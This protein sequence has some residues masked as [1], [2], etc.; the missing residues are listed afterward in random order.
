MEEISTTNSEYP[1]AIASFMVPFTS[2]PLTWK[3]FSSLL[4]HCT[5]ALTSK[6]VGPKYEAPNIPCIYGSSSY[7]DVSCIFN[8]SRSLLSI[9]AVSS[10]CA[11]FMYCIYIQI[12]EGCNF[13]GLPKSRISAILFSWISSVLSY[14]VLQVYY[15]CFNKIS[16]I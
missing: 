8:Y 4:H 10:L 6:N 2:I 11:V 16:R 13:C 1:A 12:F 5:P 14:L 7:D 9:Y 15:N 3:W